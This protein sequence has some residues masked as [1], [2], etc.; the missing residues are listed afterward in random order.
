MLWIAFL[1]GVNVGGSGKLAMG[2]LR[3]I[4]SGLGCGAPQTYIQSGNVIFD[5]DDPADDVARRISDAIK[6][7][8]GFRPDVVAMTEADLARIVRAADFPGDPARTHAFLS[9]VPITSVDGAAIERLRAETETWRLA[10]GVFL[11][12]AP[13]GIGRSRLAAGVGRLLP[14]PVTAR[15]LRT[16]QAVLELARARLTPA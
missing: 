2:D 6:A 1:R 4:L 12:H 13:D 11:L 15:N 14:A 9:A 5:S 10:E 7:Q 16:L 3:D 8:A